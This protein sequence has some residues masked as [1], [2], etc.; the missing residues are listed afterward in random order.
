VRILSPFISICKEKI[1]LI[2]TVS[3]DVSPRIRSSSDVCFGWGRRT[4][5]QKESERSQCQ[6][7]EYA[8]ML[9]S[10]HPFF[11]FEKNH[12]PIYLTKRRPTSSIPV[13]APGDVA[14][15]RSY[16]A[17]PP[18]SDSRSPLRRPRLPTQQRAHVA[19][20]C[21][22]GP[23]I[24]LSGYLHSLMDFYIHPLKDLVI[25]I[26]S[27]ISNSSAFIHPLSTV[28]STCHFV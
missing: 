19:M 5:K 6:F 22:S 20:P 27:S 3:V 2:S 7:R 16:A 21:I 12:P 13:P 17:I 26:F 1:S 14:S 15:L 4:I 9:P 18:V 8:P 11:F 28:G 24:S 10:R 23:R 25:K